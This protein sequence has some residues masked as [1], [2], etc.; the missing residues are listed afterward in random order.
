MQ[1]VA[2]EVLQDE[3]QLARANQSVNAVGKVPN[4]SRETSP[5]KQQVQQ[6]EAWLSRL[7][8]ARE[9]GLK[10]SSTGCAE[11][12]GL[13]LLPGV[14]EAPIVA[15]LRDCLSW[16][17]KLPYS[18]VNA[19]DPTVANSTLNSWRSLP[20]APHHPMTVRTCMLWEADLQRIAN[21]E[22][23]AIPQALIHEH[24]VS[25][26]SAARESKIEPFEDSVVVQ[27]TTFV[28]EP[29]DD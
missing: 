3:S 15:E 13:L 27:F 23:D 16:L 7:Q 6:E 22:T 9:S 20:R 26:L 24:E 8:S 1:R 17:E 21:H 14:R 4:T 29:P 25:P 19:A 5:F 2:I 11:E 10:R 12:L 18:F 28:S